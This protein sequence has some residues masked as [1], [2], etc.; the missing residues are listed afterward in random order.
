MLLRECDLKIDRYDAAEVLVSAVIA[1]ESALAR[2]AALKVFDA[3]AEIRLALE[4]EI[5]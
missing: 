1:S 4:K 5:A 2:I 3:A